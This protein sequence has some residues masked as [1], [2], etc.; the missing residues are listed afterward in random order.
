MDK[1]KQQRP[2]FPYTMVRDHKH[3]KLRALETYPKVVILWKFRNGEI[4]T[5]IME[6][7]EAINYFM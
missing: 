2:P 5:I 4:P 7:K 3:G 6:S 1:L